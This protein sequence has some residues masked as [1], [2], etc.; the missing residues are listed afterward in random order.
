MQVEL[1]KLKKC[2]EK[3]KELIGNFSDED[4]E[5]YDRVYNELHKKVRAYEILNDNLSSGKTKDATESV[6]EMDKLE[7]A[8]LKLTQYLMSFLGCEQAPQPQPQPQK[9][10]VKDRGARPG[11]V[12]IRPVT[13]TY[14]DNTGKKHFRSNNNKN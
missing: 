1:L 11:A 9:V 14:S 8:C 3:N 5:E 6:S 12:S 7:T 13:T 10:Q 4:K 2:I